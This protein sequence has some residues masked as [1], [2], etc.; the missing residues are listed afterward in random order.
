MIA[1]PDIVSKMKWWIECCKHN[2]SAH[3]VGSHAVD[4]VLEGLDGHG[5]ECDGCC[6]FY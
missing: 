2:H 6:G 5:P 3:H 1:L 4:E